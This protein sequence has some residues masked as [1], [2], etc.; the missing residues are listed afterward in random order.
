MNSEELIKLLE[1]PSNSGVF[2]LGPFDPGITLL[3]QQT[4]AL[5]LIYALKENK[6]IKKKSTIAVIGGGVAGLT[7][8]AAAQKVGCKVTLIEKHHSLLHLQQ[9]CD[10][11]WLQPYIYNWP[12]SGSLNDYA[13]LPVLSWQSGT[14]SSVAK[15]I[16][17]KFKA[18]EDKIDLHLSAEITSI[19]DKRVICSSRT[20][21]SEK[22]NMDRYFD[23]VIYCVGFG[24][25]SHTNR[26]WPPYW[27]NDSFHQIDPNLDLEGAKKFLITGTGDGGLIDLMRTTILNFNHATIH[28]DLFGDITAKL[29][30]EL[31]KIKK[32]WTELNHQNQKS[33]WLYDQYDKLEQK[34]LLSKVLSKISANIR[35]DTAISLNGKPAAFKE[36]LSLSNASMFSTLIAYCLHQLGAFDYISGTVKINSNIEEVELVTDDDSPPHDVHE[37][38]QIIIRHGADFIKNYQDACCGDEI[39]KEINDPN[40]VRNH[41]NTAK[42]LWPAGWWEGSKVEHV[43]PHTTALA[44]TFVSTLRDHLE[45][46]CKELK[47]GSIPN[48]TIGFRITLHRITEIQGE[49]YY[50]QIARYARTNNEPNKP[51]LK[52]VGRLF[53]TNNGIGGLSCRLGKPISLQKGASFKAFIKQLNLQA[54]VGPITEETKSFLVVPF[55]SVYRRKGVDNKK[56]KSVIL[57]LFASSNFHN[58]FSDEVLKTIYS[59]CKGFV[60]NIE[61]M[62]EHKEVYCHQFNYER[63]I[64]DENKKEEDNLWLSKYNNILQADMSVFDKYINDLTF[65]SIGHFELFSTFDKL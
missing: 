65:N 38:D 37:Y 63:F 59:S 11:R 27:R 57:L 50:Q 42:R 20:R 49:Y 12:E 44:T 39:L 64:P 29:R 26:S 21:Q 51:T 23:F 9:G 61:E 32:Q 53:P 24:I 31:I 17:Q 52:N 7:T 36:C 41:F 19:D 15:Q 54:P 40:F 4:R 58:F 8:A 46:I 2:V 60:K 22:I 25:E 14:A 28:Y 16:L 1:I 35:P 6:K 56:A 30:R 3:K 45:H 62:L 43:A 34:G 5:N 48:Q 55:F 47:T 13:D 18:F 33:F 10:T